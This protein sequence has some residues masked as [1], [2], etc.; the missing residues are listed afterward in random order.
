MKIGITLGLKKPNESMWINGIKLNAIFLMNA[1]QK[2]GNKV[3]LLDTSK[4]V[5]R[6]KSGKLNDDELVWDSKK[7]PVYDYRKTVQTCDVLILLGVAV[8]P[9]EVDKF[10]LTGPNKKV[11]KYACGNNY[12]IDMENMIHKEGEAVDN[13]GVTFN[14]NIDEVWYVPQQGYQNQD[15]YSILHQLPKEK[16][17]AVPF[18]WDPMFIDEIESSYGGMI[19]DENGN[20][21]QKTDN[22]PVYQPGKKVEDLELTTF[23]PNLNVVKFSMIPMLI[24][25]QYLHKGGEPFKRLNIISA[26][27]LYKNS[28]WRKFIQKLNLTQKTNNEGKPLLAVQHRFPI[29]YILSKMTDIVLSHQWENPLNYAYLDVMYLQFPLIHN[30]D[31]IKDAGYFY[32][33]FEAEK[34]AEL[35]KWVIDNHDNNIDAYN[36]KNEEVLTRYTVYNEGLVE[37]YKKLLENLYAGEN[38]HGLS[39]DYDWKTNLYK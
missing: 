21:M 25:E 9:E 10:R 16:V 1:L 15:Y 37:T 4:T 23:E 35:L 18:V 12:V 17:F 13:M 5:S 30:A 36:E 14:Q 3:V 22:I 32:P 26:A 27:R 39:L 20:E 11:I 2:T 24:A 34:G 29:H 38:K 7:F 19:V 33:D 28:L 8:G 31:M 6:S